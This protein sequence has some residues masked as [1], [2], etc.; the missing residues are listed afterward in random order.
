ML[1]F[2]FL[3][4]SLSLS[5]SLP[6]FLSLSL[7]PSLSL[8]SSLSL[9]LSLSLPLSLSFPLDRH[10]KVFEI[11][12]KKIVIEKFLKL[13]FICSGS[14]PRSGYR[15]CR[16]HGCLSIKKNEKNKRRN[17]E[18]NQREEK[19][20]KYLILLYQESLYQCLLQH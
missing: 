11:F 1:F 8:F 12:A 20:R 19:K 6:V 7:F 5:L 16:I 15:S 3:F 4:S 2:P 13:S 10:R 9:S 17:K 14:S 18:T